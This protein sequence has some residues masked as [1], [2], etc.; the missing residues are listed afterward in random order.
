MTATEETLPCQGLGQHD[1]IEADPAG[2]LG[3]EWG[4]LSPSMLSLSIYL[5][6]SRHILIRLEGRLTENE[7]AWFFAWG[8]GLLGIAGLKTFPC[9]F[10]A[11]IINVRKKTTGTFRDTFRF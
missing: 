7:L 2:A 10:S 1:E 6:L 5:S 9:L 4:R 3:P 8:V 11:A